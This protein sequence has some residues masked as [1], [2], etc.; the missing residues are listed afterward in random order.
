[1]TLY[2]TLSTTTVLNATTSR[3]EIKC[4]FIVVDKL[5]IMSGAKGT[6][7]THLHI[8]SHRSIINTKF[9]LALD[10][11]LHEYK[12]K[13]FVHVDLFLYYV[14]ITSDLNAK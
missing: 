8:I 7:Q 12:S 1:M 3:L 6:G 2:V 14:T 9:G 13:T 11:Y 4:N 10:W 5:Y